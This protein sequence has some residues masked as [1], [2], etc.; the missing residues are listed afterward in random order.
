[1]HKALFQF[2]EFCLSGL[3]LYPA[4]VFYIPVSLGE[5]TLQ[6]IKDIYLGKGRDYQFYRFVVFLRSNTYENIPLNTSAYI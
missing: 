1:M 6:S 3:K 5:L 4:F 2:S